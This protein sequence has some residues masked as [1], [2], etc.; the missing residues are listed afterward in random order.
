M[1]IGKFGLSHMDGWCG[2]LNQT[3]LSGPTIWRFSQQATRPANMD[4]IFKMILASSKAGFAV[5]RPSN[6]GSL[7]QKSDFPGDSA[8]PS[9]STAFGQPLVNLSHLLG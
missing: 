2:G 3:L 6:E 8:W 9:G 7:G 5:R 4:V 1:G